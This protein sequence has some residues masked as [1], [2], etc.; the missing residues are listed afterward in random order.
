M[1]QTDRVRTLKSRFQGDFVLTLASGVSL[2]SG[3]SYR[4][5]IRAVFGC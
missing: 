2:K 4:A 1:V 3:R 5:R